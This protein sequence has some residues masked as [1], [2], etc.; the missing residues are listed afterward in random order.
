LKVE[1]DIVDYLFKHEELLEFIKKVAHVGKNKGAE[2]PYV[3]QDGRNY[4]VVEGNTRIAAYKVLTGLV[5]VPA[6][7]ESQIPHVSDDLRSSLLVVDCSIAPNRDSLLSIMAEAHF[8][9][10]DKSKWGYLGSRKVLFDE[11]KSGKT[12]AQLS[13]AFGIAQA[14]VVD[15]LLEYELYLE[16]LNLV[17]SAEERQKL[18]DPRVAFNPPVRFLQTKGHKDRV[19]ITYDRTNL[20]IRFESPEA[21]RKFQH[22][23][24]KLVVSPQQGLGATASYEDVFRDFIPTPSPAPTSA[25]PADPR[26]QPNPAGGPSASPSAPTHGQQPSPPPPPPLGGA[27]LKK[28]ALFN[29]EVTVHSSLLRQLMKEAATINAQRLP[30]SGMFLMRNIME[31]IL[32][33][34]IER[35]GANQDKRSITLES[36]LTI[37]QSS[38]VQLT[39]EDKKILKSFMRDHLDVLNLGAHASIIPDYLRL[40]SI[41]NAIDNFVRRH[42]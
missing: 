16:A 19:G 42:V 32:K 23:I 6:D 26:P 34:I 40:I 15:Y 4:T 29:Y 27:K 24:R 35:D 18:L 2:R 33:N 36:A 39:S 11:N 28:G 21:R 1:Q 14:E 12:Y 3:V 41:R 5:T 7:L 13:R 31:A 30:A 10:G 37:C 25:T 22:L 8:G 9:T 38:S 20:K 17:W